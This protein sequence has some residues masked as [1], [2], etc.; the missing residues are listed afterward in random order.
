MGQSPVPKISTINVTLVQC[1][2]GL[3]LKSNDIDLNPD[4]NMAYVFDLICNNNMSHLFVFGIDGVLYS[5]EAF[6]DQNNVPA[7]RILR[8]GDTIYIYFNR[9]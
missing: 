8:D 9:R 1:T 6:E 2:A 5:R 3:T 7:K 4:M